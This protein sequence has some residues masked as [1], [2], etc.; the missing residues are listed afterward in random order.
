MAISIDLRIL[1]SKLEKSSDELIA[2]AALKG[3][4]YLEKISTAIAAASTLLT[5]VADDIDTNLTTADLSSS[6]LDKIATLSEK[7]ASSKDP[8]IRKQANVLDEI[9]LTIAAPKN[10]VAEAKQMKEDAVNELAAKYRSDKIDELYHKPKKDLHKMHGFADMAKAVDT[11]VKDFRPLEAPLQTRYSPDMPGTPMVRITDGVYQDVTTGKIFDYINGYSTAKGNKIP[12][13]SV[14]NQIRDLGD[15]RH[16]SGMFETRDTILNRSIS[17]SSDERQYMKKFAQ[18]DLIGSTLRMI[19][20]FKP[21]LL[22]NAIDCAAEKNKLNTDEIANALSNDVN[23][24][25]DD[26]R[27]TEV[28][29]GLVK[30]P[31][32]KVSKDEQ[33]EISKTHE[34]LKMLKSV[35]WDSMILDLFDVVMRD[36]IVSPKN[37]IKLFADFLPQDVVS[38][39]TESYVPKH[40][41]NPDPANIYDLVDMDE[42]DVVVES[43]EE[44]TETKPEVTP[45]KTDIDAVRKAFFEKINFEKIATEKKNQFSTKEWFDVFDI[46]SEPFFY[47]YVQNNKLDEGP[48]AEHPL[49]QLAILFESQI[50]QKMNLL[51]YPGPF[52]VEPKTKKTYIELAV[53]FERS[54]KSVDINL[55][56]EAK[57]EKLDGAK[58][59]KLEDPT[60]SKPKAWSPGSEQFDSAINQIK[61]NPSVVGDEDFWNKIFISAPGHLVKLKSTIESIPEIVAKRKQD[62][63]LD[64]FINDWF[65]YLEYNKI[66]IAPKKQTEAVITD[67][68]KKIVVELP[69]ERQN[70]EW[71]KYRQD[72]IQWYKNEKAGPKPQEPAKYPY[73]THKGFIIYV[74]EEEE[75]SLKPDSYVSVFKNVRGLIWDAYKEEYGRRLT[76]EQVQEIKQIIDSTMVQKGYWPP[77][78]SITIPGARSTVKFGP[79]ISKKLRW[80]SLP[81]EEQV[82]ELL[83]EVSGKA[84]P[85]KDSEEYLE[86]FDSVSKMTQEDLPDYVEDLKEKLNVSELTFAQIDAE[87]KLRV[88]QFMEYEGFVAPY[89]VD[90]V[91][92]RTWLEIAESLAN[93]ETGKLDD[94][95]SK[96]LRQKEIDSMHDESTVNPRELT[97]KEKEEAEVRKQQILEDEPYSYTVEPNKYN[98]WLNLVNDLNNTA[99]GLPTGISRNNYLSTKMHKLDLPAPQEIAPNGMTWLTYVKSEIEKQQKQDDK[100]K[101]KQVETQKRKQQ[102]FKLLT[103]VDN[104]LKYISVLSDVLKEVGQN[105]ELAAKIERER[106]KNNKI[107]AGKGGPSDTVNYTFKKQK[108]DL[109]RELMFK[110]G[111][112]SPYDIDPSSNKTWAELMNS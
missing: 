37:I 61:S 100:L 32:A 48:G 93:I 99:G 39:Y 41:Q 79:L 95:Y 91:S 12:G 87:Y 49:I 29:K 83:T 7:L 64:Q 74:P 60:Y 82:M 80:A 4:E 28:F 97:N 6:D 110:K 33:E 109:I 42:P 69:K 63:A 18:M 81:Y 2:E 46:E 51:G 96:Y 66:G 50:T 70:P 44:N 38:S 75:E 68:T 31:P 24:V 59:E 26:E 57:K 102:F 108:E 90:P 22:N 92:S 58:K 47:E 62:P 111:F 54:G 112:V 25:V 15:Q 85:H 53:E 88:N 36:K 104:K 5:S 56:P 8:E 86:T 10:A 89:S 35:G 11:Q 101:S 19:R 43:D 94:I 65:T 14:A 40:M 105:N 16:Q 107:L 17:A 34:L 55:K 23:S 52:E 67:Q 84:T 98:H 1:A 3:P 45:V 78:T 77:Y 71:V 21:E 30:A 13:C 27:V 72:L 106:K 103:P 9:L 76:D 20:D 73:S